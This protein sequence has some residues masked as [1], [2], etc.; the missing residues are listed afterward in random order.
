[1]QGITTVQ[2][3]YNAQH[4]HHEPF[5]VVAG[6]G[7]TLF[8]RNWFYHICLDW[9]AIKQVTPTPVQLVSS[10]MRWPRYT[11]GLPS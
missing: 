3:N 4:S 10:A 2:V 7:Q 6:V 8:G 1:M 11:T 9:Q 5:I